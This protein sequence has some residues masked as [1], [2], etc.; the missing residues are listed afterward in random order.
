MEHNHPELSISRQCE[1]LGLSRSSFYYETM[2][3]DSED[4]R[5]MR[6]IDEKYL[7]Y[8]FYG[9]RKL[10]D[11]IGKDLGIAINRKR[12]QRLMRVMG[13][14]A[15]YPKPNLS[16]ADAGHKKFPYLLRDLKIERPNHVW[17]C[18]ITYIPLEHGFA[19]LVAVI[20]WY[21]R[22]VLAWRLSNTMTVGFCLEALEAALQHGKPVIFNTDQGSQFTCNDFTSILLNNGIQVSMDGKGR[23]LDNVFIE[24]LWRS[25]KYEDIYIRGYKQMPEVFQGLESYFR[26]Y[27]EIRPHQSLGYVPP[28]EIHY[29]A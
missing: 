17:S 14:E 18:D 27:N 29:A 23:A 26:F 13:I 3:C 6:L 10:A 20:D 22:Y 5:F 21:S 4:L 19:Y 28:A 2:T 7:K 25:V 8:P 9:S 24:R 11:T 12:I 1:L 15:I 16:R